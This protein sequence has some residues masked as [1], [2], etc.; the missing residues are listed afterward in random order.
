[1]YGRYRAKVFAILW[2]ITHLQYLWLIR[3][4]LIWELKM[5]KANEAKWHKNKYI[6]ESLTDFGSTNTCSWVDVEG[7]GRWG[8]HDS[9]CS[10]NLVT[11]GSGNMK[12]SSTCDF[13][14]RFLIEINHNICFRLIKKNRITRV[15]TNRTKW[16]KFEQKIK[17]LAKMMNESAELKMAVT[18]F[19]Q[20]IANFDQII[21]CCSHGHT[22]YVVAVHKFHT[23]H[24]NF[25]A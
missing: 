12:P 16:W 22:P 2:F 9:N 15:E 17:T 13:G 1:M 8:L 4:V 10:D 6:N 7:C 18:F 24:G 5:I 25:R 20:E 21:L 19:C 23:K 11:V 3:N 14:E